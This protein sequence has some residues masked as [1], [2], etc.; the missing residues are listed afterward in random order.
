MNGIHDMGGMQGMGPIE[1][2]HNEPVFHAAWEARAYAMNGA[3][4]ATGK[5]KGALRVPIENLTAFE[6]LRMSYYERWLWSLTERLVAS[7][8]ATRAEIES[9]HPAEGSVKSVPALSA[10]DVPAFMRRIPPLRKDQVA[11]RFQIGQHVRARNINPVTHTR[12]PRYVRGKAG[13]I[14]RDRDVATFPDFM[15][16]AKSRSTSTRCANYGAIKPQRRTPSM[17]SCGTI[18]LSQPDFADLPKSASRTDTLPQLPREKHQP[19][20][21]GGLRN[22]CARAGRCG[23]RRPRRVLWKP[24]RPICDARDA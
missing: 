14:E 1:Y 8:L 11:P 13:T 6:Y 4:T 7:G 22:P 19:R 20:D 10:A 17:S 2:E 3:V 21:R 12:L 24:A 9:G 18:T 5:L 23:L 15:G 16:L